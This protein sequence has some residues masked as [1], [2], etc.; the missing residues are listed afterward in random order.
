MQHT[1]CLFSESQGYN[2]GQSHVLRDIYRRYDIGLWTFK[3]KQILKCQT[4]FYY[5][6]YTVT[7]PLSFWLVVSAIVQW[8]FFTFIYERFISD[9]VRDFVDLCAMSNISV[10]IMQHAQYGYYIHGR[11][12]HGRADT[13]MREMCEMIKREEVSV[14]GRFSLK[15]LNCI[16]TVFMVHC[17]CIEK[18]SEL[19]APHYPQ[20]YQNATYY[21]YLHLFLISLLLVYASI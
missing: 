8:I 11:S 3:Q 13:D 6:Y 20:R 9:K 1:L 17:N 18:N 4:T 7:T 19:N 12:V 10:F 5:I 15:V 21:L 16:L 2:E 14:V